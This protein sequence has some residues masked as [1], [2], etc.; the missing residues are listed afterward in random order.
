MQASIH[1]NRLPRSR[2]SYVVAF[3]PSAAGV[4]VIIRKQ[5]A[6]GLSEVS[7]TIEDPRQLSLKIHR[8]A[9]EV[10]TRQMSTQSDKEFFANL[11][12]EEGN[13]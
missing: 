4:V 8:I 5:S 10:A 3:E 9:G 11:E 7:R 6:A 13:V 2:T 12:K 1:F